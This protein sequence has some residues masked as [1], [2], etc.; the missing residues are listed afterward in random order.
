MLEESLKVRWL[1]RKGK[2][3]NVSTSRAWGPL[4]EGLTPRAGL[5]A[6][7]SQDFYF[8]CWS[9]KSSDYWDGHGQYLLFPHPH[10]PISAL[11]GNECHN[12]IKRLSP[13][14]L[15]ESTQVYP[16]RPPTT[17]LS[18][19]PVLRIQRYI[20]WVGRKACRGQSEPRRE[21]ST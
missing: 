5:G 11:V 12:W 20:R 18:S 2:G 16:Q 6:Q 17:W 13:G 8:S 7:I 3:S 1:G 15:S 10:P 14:W 21:T 4:G 9:A 19:D